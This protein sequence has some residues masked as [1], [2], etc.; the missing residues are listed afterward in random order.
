[1]SQIHITQTGH[2]TPLLL[3]HGWGFDHSI[4]RPILSDLNK[5]YTVYRVDLPG[6]GQTPCMPFD[7]FKTNL[8]DILP[9]KIALLG[10]SM[11][12]LIATRLALEHPERI[13]CLINISASPCF[14]ASDNWP[15]ISAN[16]LDAFYQGLRDNPKA[17]LENFIRLQ[18][19]K[20][21]PYVLETPHPFNLEGLE[22]GLE[23]LKTWDFREKITQLKQP[24]SYLFGRLDSITPAKTMS[25]MQTSYPGVHCELIRGAGHAPFLSHPEAFLTFLNQFIENN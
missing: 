14:V 23:I 6:F 24:T 20:K 15:G 7:D 4:W 5:K 25:A 1:M 17:T 13:T 8:F 16:N 19:P 22:S 9:A 18:L 12:G 3:L 2:G 21:I 11:G 10:W